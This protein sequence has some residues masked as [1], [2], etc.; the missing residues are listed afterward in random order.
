MMKPKAVNEH[1]DGLLEYLEDI[2]GSNKY[3]GPIGEASAE[4]EGLNDKRLE[5]V[6]RMKIAERER[7]RLSGMRDR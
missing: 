3:I 7:D 5:K 2:I 6:N 4:L 1:E